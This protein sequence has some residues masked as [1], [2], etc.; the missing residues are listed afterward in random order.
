MLF[1]RQTRDP[2]MLYTLTVAVPRPPWNVFL[3]HFVFGLRNLCF[4]LMMRGVARGVMNSLA[5]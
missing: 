4:P 1:C 3:C 5:S 2:G